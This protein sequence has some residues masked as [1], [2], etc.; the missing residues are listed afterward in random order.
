MKKSFKDRLTLLGLSYQKEVMILILFPLVFIIGGFV[1]YYFFK[2]LIA[3]IGIGI[4]GLGLDYFYF[5]RYSKLEK[6]MERDHINEFISL[7]S[8]F[9]AFISNGNNVYNSFKMLIP[10]S[11]PF[12]DDVLNS[13]L[14][15]IDMDKSVGPYITFA[16]KFNSHVI[17]SL[18]L[19]IYQMID[20]GE[21][22]NQFTEFEFLFTNI[23]NNYSEELIEQKKKSLDS[24]NSFPLIGAGF[25]TITLSICIVSL[26]GGY[27]NVL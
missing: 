22:S 13:L 17:E 21:S 12:M 10:Y 16:S 11:S 4:A 24:L 25:L 15:Q 27:I 20:S 18:M 3:A 1:V 19:S 14:I 8:Y 2:E 9:E 26:I 6:E 5:S 7:M 23:K